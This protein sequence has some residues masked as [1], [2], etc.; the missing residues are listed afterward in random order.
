MKL[1]IFQETGEFRIAQDGEWFQCYPDAFIQSKG[2]SLVR[3]KIFAMTEV[4]AND[5]IYG[6]K[7]TLSDK[8][9]PF[10]KSAYIPIVRPKPKVKKWQ[11]LFKRNDGLLDTTPL[12][13]NEEEVLAYIECINNGVYA[14]EV[15]RK[16]EESE[17]E[18]E[19]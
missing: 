5:D 4:E 18:V 7:I 1:Y 15:L 19:E 6:A 9:S 16:L 3:Q 17:S 11:W 8:S 2:A 12:Y 10:C 13:K 14:F